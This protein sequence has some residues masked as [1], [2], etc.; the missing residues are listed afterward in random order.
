MKVEENKALVEALKYKS[1]QNDI[2][3][4]F[5]KAQ[6]LKVT[7]FTRVQIALQGE[8]TK[9]LPFHLGFNYS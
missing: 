9:C 4:L 1:F 3:P 7:N 5:S 8:L 2:F 6:I